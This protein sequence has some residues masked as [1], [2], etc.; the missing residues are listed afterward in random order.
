MVTR[1]EGVDES[2]KTAPVN[3]V[4]TEVRVVHA[5]RA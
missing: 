5:I 4:V 2:K 1:N 3:F